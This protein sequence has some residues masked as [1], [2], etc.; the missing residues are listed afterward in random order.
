MTDRVEKLT[1]AALHILELLAVFSGLVLFGSVVIG[2]LV[3]TFHAAVAGRVVAVPFRGNDER[4]MELT[5]VFVRRLTEIEDEWIALAN[6][7]EGVRKEIDER[8]RERGDDVKPSAGTPLT[9]GEE[10]ALPARRGEELAT[11]APRT[12]GDELLFGVVELAGAGSMDNADLGGISLGGVTFSPRE[13]VALLRSA[14]IGLARRTLKGSIISGSELSTLSVEFEE[15]ALPVFGRVRRRAIRC[16]FQGDDWPAAVEELAFRLEKERIYL[17]R[18]R[19]TLR[20]RRR[21]RGTFLREPT[22]RSHTLR[23]AVIEADSWASYRPFLVGYAAHLRHYRDGRATDRDGALEHYDEALDAQPGFPRAAYNKALLLYNRYLPDANEEAIA[24]FTLAIE[25]QDPNLK[26]LALA[27]L[28]M[29][30]C[31]AINR[32][33]SD[34]P[35]HDRL[36]REAARDAIEL[37]ED[38]EEPVF[39][40][41][42]ILELD[43]LWHDALDRYDAVLALKGTSGAALRIKSSA[44]NNKAAL[45]LR[46]LADEDNALSRAEAFLW[47]AIR[48]YPNKAAYTNLG[49][50]AR[51][52]DRI[53]DAVRL[54]ETAVKLDRTYANAWNELAVVELEQA[55]ELAREG[56]PKNAD[57]AVR[58]SLEHAEH[59]ERL[60]G[61]NTRFADLLHNKFSDAV[62]AFVETGFPRR[63]GWLES[64][65]PHR[66]SPR[67]DDAA[68]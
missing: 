50:V 41:A 21:L 6:D 51:R 11:S 56:R 48:V 59:A 19:P 28:A 9:A 37:A 17:V 1:Q 13:I 29:G 30:H 31:Q 34:S 46:Q 62:E 53:A 14:P 23:Q 2:L 40:Q 3:A 8:A 67:A 44:L 43:Q 24:A 27:G 32:Y 36:A 49:E 68:G 25:T 55:S 22:T 18:D 26:P 64:L 58:A 54:I 61:M 39:A 57:V 42:R 60:A 15:R 65:E 38:L 33:A 7:V 5:H 52:S 66:K 4:R 47:Q 10:L 45:L 63:Y 20:M 35:D 16:Q 12:S